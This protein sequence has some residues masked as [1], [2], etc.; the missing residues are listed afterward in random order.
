MTRES[1]HYQIQKVPLI[2]KYEE[3]VVKKEKSIGKNTVLVDF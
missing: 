3:K 2:T 1:Y